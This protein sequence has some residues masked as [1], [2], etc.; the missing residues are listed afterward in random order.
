MSGP[1]TDLL[2]LRL[3]NRLFQEE[4]TKRIL[5]RPHL[6]SINLDK[7]NIQMFLDLMKT[8]QETLGLRP[9]CPFSSFDFEDLD[10]DSGMTESFCQRTD[11]QIRRLALRANTNTID[12]VVTVLAHSS[13]LVDLKCTSQVV[14]LSPEQ[15]ARL[16]ATFQE[17]RD[18]SLELRYCADF[19]NREACS[20]FVALSRRSPRLERVRIPVLNLY[21]N[22]IPE[23]KILRLLVETHSSS[24]LFSLDNRIKI[25][26]TKHIPILTG[27]YVI[28]YLS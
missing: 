17:L 15:L 23:M 8:R 16:P 22:E 28:I 2:S 24:L 26:C 13:R 25:I 7:P 19:I 9:I 14:T 20:L 6:H 3:I 21:S 27:M 4:A 18:L 12:N 11:G 1:T 5:A 10:W